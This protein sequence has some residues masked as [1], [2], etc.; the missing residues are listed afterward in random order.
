MKLYTFA[1]GTQSLVK[2]YS[3]SE[4]RWMEKQHGKCIRVETVNW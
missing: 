3:A 2:K 4:L 1:D